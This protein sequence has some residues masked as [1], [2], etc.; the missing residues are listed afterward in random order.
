MSYQVLGDWPYSS[1][2]IGLMSFWGLLKTGLSRSSF[3]VPRTA[4]AHAF[5]LGNLNFQ[6]ASSK[7]VL[8]YLL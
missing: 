3:N 6:G 4:S 2:T 8:D 1:I 5:V 7:A